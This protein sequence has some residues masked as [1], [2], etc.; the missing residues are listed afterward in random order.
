MKL[1]IDKLIDAFILLT[2]YVTFCCCHGC[3]C[4]HAPCPH[5]SHRG[6]E[7]QWPGSGYTWGCL[8]SVATETLTHQPLT[9]LTLPWFHCS[10]LFYAVLLLMFANGAPIAL[11][12][13]IKYSQGWRGLG[14]LTY[15]D[16]LVAHESLISTLK[17]SFKRS[18]LY[19]QSNWCLDTPTSTSFMVH[20]GC[21]TIEFALCFACF[22]GF[23]CSYRRSFYHFSTAQET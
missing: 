23:Q 3:P 16:T 21:P 17:L 9:F 19:I 13:M 20:T 11:I 7:W 5:H 1:I 12:M 4:L 22:L 2:R 14:S 6:H 8:T 18:Y 15:L 10:D